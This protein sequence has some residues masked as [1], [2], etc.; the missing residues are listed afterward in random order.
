MQNRNV[1]I[2]GAGIAGPTLAYWLRRHG[3]SP[4]IVER[5][6]AP[7]TGGYMIDFWGVGYDVAE[8]M[9][10]LPT[11]RR[12]GYRLD[13]LCIVD[14]RG[15]RIAGFHVD[16]LQSATKGRYLSM[17]RSDLA[18]ALYAL[19]A[20]DVEFIFGDSIARLD[21]DDAGVTVTFEHHPPRRFDLVVGADGLHSVVR[22]L[23]FG[24]EARFE[25]YLGYYT[26]AFSAPGYPHRDEGAYVSYAVPKRQLAR[27]A[28]RENR[29]AFFMIFAQD[30]VLGLGHDDV[31]AQRRILRETFSGIGWEADEI[32]AAMESA[33][34]LYF[35]AVAQ[36]RLS[37]WSRG[38]VALLGD[39]AYCPSLLAGQGSALA[40][41]GAQVLAHELAAANGDHRAAF[42]AYERRFKPFIDAKQKSA[43]RFG[44]WFAPRTR[45]ALTLRNLATKALA[46]PWI[47]DR[48]V[49]RSLGDQF[50]LPA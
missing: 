20:K 7:R 39:A 35:D 43:E 49:V 41:A 30:Q 16:A 14:H 38:R 23:T 19:V 1:I 9:D 34:D 6:P 3:F 44:G 45:F 29:S 47:G 13:E 32:L 11:L 17:M 5:A 28:L 25:K 8:Q 18:H 21:E 26:A 4:T 15:R 31:A 46:F 40:M 12:V 24:P 48:L 27:Y 42:A 50:E 2:S 36:T 33:D 22:T 37:S 10:L